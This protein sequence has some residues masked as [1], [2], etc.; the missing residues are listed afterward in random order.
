M[1]ILD[2]HAL[3]TQGLAMTNRP[4]SVIL[5]ALARSIHF[6]DSRI[7]RDSLTLGESKSNFGLLRLAKGKSRN[8]EVG[9]FII[10][11]FAQITTISSLRGQCP[12]QSTFHTTFK[13]IK[14]Q[15]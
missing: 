8:D 5:R 2:C 15:T 1:R 4:R 10:A 6:N 3:A 9:K 14:M 11:R 7:T 12:K 13:G